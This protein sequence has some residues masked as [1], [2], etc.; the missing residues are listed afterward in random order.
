MWLYHHQN[1]IAYSNSCMEMTRLKQWVNI[2]TSLSEIRRKKTDTREIK[3]RVRAAA[4]VWVK[5]NRHVACDWPLTV[6]SFG[7]H[8]KKK[9]GEEEQPKSSLSNQ[10][11]IVTPTFQYNMD[12]KKVGKCIIINNKNFED[13]TGNVLCVL[14]REGWTTWPPEVLSNL[15]C[16]VILLMTFIT[17]FRFFTLSFINK[18]IIFR[19][20]NL[21]TILTLFEK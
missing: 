20:L 9:N 4:I 14:E 1:P 18:P 11:R 5:I 12:Y 7:S 21:I 3:T 10:Y 2:S 6:F 16:S 13:K 17:D 8:R 19:V 15:N